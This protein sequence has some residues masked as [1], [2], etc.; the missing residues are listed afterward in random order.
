[1]TPPSDTQTIA[2]AVLR[3]FDAVATGDWTAADALL[4]D[5]VYVAHGS[6]QVTLS[7]KELL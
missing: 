3:F 6:D 2:D 1:M 5:S 7:S 4:A